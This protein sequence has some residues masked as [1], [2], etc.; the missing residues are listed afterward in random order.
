MKKFISLMSVVMSI[1]LIGLT[2][3][4]AN[5]TS[6]QVTTSVQAT[7]DTVSSTP[8]K[9]GYVIGFLNPYIGNNWRAALLA[10][11][12]EIGK[13]YKEDGKIKELVVA[14]SNN[15]VTQQLSQMDNMINN[16]VDAIVI[17]PTS[18]TALG[19]TIKKAQ[20]QGILVV[21]HTSAA[22]IPGTINVIHDSESYSKTNAE[23]L[24]NKMGDKGN[25]VNITGLSGNMADNLRLEENKKIF[26][27]HPNI[28]VLGEA[29]ADWSDTKA[30]SVMSTFLSSFQQI[31]GVLQQDVTALGVVRAYE[32]S[33]KKLPVMTGDYFYG[34]LRKWAATPDL[35]S[36]AYTMQAASGADAIGVALRLL[37]GKK[38]KDGVLKPNPLDKS[39]VNCYMLE[40]PYIVTN[41]AEPDA[42]YMKDFKFTKSI[43]VQEA[44][45]LSEGKADSDSLDGIM[46]DE[47]IDTLFK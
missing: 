46:T 31:D 20:D 35:Q 38:F 33:N 16:K 8:K 13:K 41:E 30:Q 29:P 11:V 43:S 44:V 2:G 45:K 39:L 4:G 6:N 40:P 23:W 27:Q 3:C 36:M 22:N 24:F 42:A 18:V 19:P 9:D 37:D 47:Q 34:F 17:E 15:D 26:P 12:A 28:K 32:N 5:Q 21:I 10:D 7:N 1:V 25:I 14:S